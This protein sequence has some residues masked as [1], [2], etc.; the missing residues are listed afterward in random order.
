MYDKV[1]LW[2][3]RY[4]IAEAYTDIPY[5]LEN[6][7]EL[8]DPDTGEVK[9]FGRLRGLR[10]NLYTGGVMIEGSLAKYHNGG[11]NVEPLDRRGTAEAIEHLSDL[12]HCK[13]DG[14]KVTYMEFGTNFLMSHEV[15]EYLIRLG[16]M[17]WLQR[18]ESFGSLY[19]QGKGKKKPKVF[20]FYD[21]LSD[22]DVK[23]MD[24]PDNLRGQNLL[25]YEMR[26]KHRLPA[27]LKVAEVNA[28]TLSEKAFYRH[29]VKLY[30][31][32]YF[33]IRK[34]SNKIDM[35]KI[36]TTPAK[37]AE[38]ILGAL[39]SMADPDMVKQLIER[40]EFED[41]KSSTR[42]KDKINKAMNEANK[43]KDELIKEL[44]DCVENCSAWI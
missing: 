28:S 42:L 31:D 44:D 21:K 19:Y 16:E 29:M 4:K 12:L 5:Y 6:S 2:L 14:A 36:K 17:P 24:Y 22:A 33:S 1:K 13:I 40:Y 15:N 26:F 18:I 37:A 9:I 34:H 8:T 20:T 7:W 43:G 11:N 35:T 38:G 39:V 32:Y 10:V 27:L 23:G 25:R 3:D 41:A 30:R